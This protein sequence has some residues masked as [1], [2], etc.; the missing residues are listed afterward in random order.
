MEV[1]QIDRIRSHAKN[2][3][4][5][6]KNC[7]PLP[8]LRE[9]RFRLNVPLALRTGVCWPVRKKWHLIG[10]IQIDQIAGSR[11]RHRREN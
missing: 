2:N 8:I 3:N 9:E 4:R 1:L 11:R 7:S 6:L 10:R 5:R